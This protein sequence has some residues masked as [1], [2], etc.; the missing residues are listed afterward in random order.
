[1]LA[2]VA[3]GLTVNFSYGYLDPEYDDYLFA[4]PATGFVPVDVSDDAHFPLASEQNASV[5]IQYDFAPFSFGEL[6]ARLDVAYNDGYQQGTLDSDF[7]KFTEAEAFTLVNGRVTLSEVEIAD[8]SRIRFAL[9]GKNLTDEE[10]RV[11][12]ITAFEQLGFAGA[13]F[14]EPR[15]YGLDIIFDYE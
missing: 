13:V 10:Y 12:G 1:M 7:D 4:S 2:L 15:S 11:F 3:E 6:S 9:W 14:N 8:S 5:G